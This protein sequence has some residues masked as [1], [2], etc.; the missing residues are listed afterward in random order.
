MTDDKP[1]R[2]KSLEKELSYLVNGTM[3]T[4][5]KIKRLSDAYWQAYN[6]AYGDAMAN[7]LMSGA[8]DEQTREWE[9]NCEHKYE[10]DELLELIQGAD[11]KEKTEL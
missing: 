9:K 5:Q 11:N 8:E 3:M 6:S 10:I 2:I 1:N 7:K 4:E